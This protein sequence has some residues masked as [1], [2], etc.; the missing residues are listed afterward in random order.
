[1]K[2]YF[3]IPLIC[4]LNLFP[5]VFV[6]AQEESSTLEQEV[7]D[8][9]FLSEEDESKDLE[10]EISEEIDLET[11][12]ASPDTNPKQAKKEEL[13]EDFG[14]DPS[15]NSDS[16]EEVE[17]DRK[18]NNTNLEESV[19]TSDE[20]PSEKEL[21][22]KTAD[23]YQTFGN[24]H[25]EWGIYFHYGYQ[26]ASVSDD[27]SFADPLPEE[28]TDMGIDVYKHLPEKPYFFGGRLQIMSESVETS[29]IVSEY[30]MNLLTG[31][32]GYKFVDDIV[33]VGATL[34]IILP[35]SGSATVS[36]LSGSASA[37]KDLEIGLS[38]TMGIVSVVKLKRFHVGFDGGLMVL[39]SQ[40]LDGEDFDTNNG[41]YFRLLLGLAL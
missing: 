18:S 19:G 22:F 11:E 29:T 26:F 5:N 27:F 36:T 1:M 6:L 4:L 30:Q 15:G 9:D 33:S 20:D 34:G 41:G 25:Y 16:T 3:L 13:G 35:I 10:S 28:Y 39:Q 2:Y 12:E 31:F 21:Q 32:V 23:S 37:D 7:S 8:D 24:K 17:N 40:K 14:E 38:Y